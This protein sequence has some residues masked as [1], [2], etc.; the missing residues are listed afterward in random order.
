MT[1]SIPRL[2][3]LSWV[4]LSLFTV[5]SVAEPSFRTLEIEQS[6]LFEPTALARA[7]DSTSDV[8]QIVVLLHG[9]DMGT[10]E[11]G[12]KYEE[13]ARLVSERLA[14]RRALVLGIQWDSGGHSF[15][16]P[17]GDYFATLQ[18]ARTIGRG[19]IRQLL[20][21]LH[22]RYPAAPV[23]LLAH[24]M[25]SEIALA[26]VAPEI[27]YPEQAPEGETYRPDLEVRLALAVFAGSDLDYDIWKQS[28]EAAMNWFERVGLTWI[29]VADPVGQGDKV[30]SLRTRF[31]GKAAG[32]LMPLMTEAQLDR[33]LPAGKLLLDDEAIP[34]DHEL[35]SYFRPA[36]IE[37][38]VA[39][40]RFRTDLRARPPELAA[41]ATVMHTPNEL[42]ALRRHLDS[43]HAGAA[44]VALW[45]LEHL[46]CGDSRHL[47]DQTLEEAVRLL[48]D[49]PKAIWPLQAH[50]PCHT[51]R[52][53]LFPSE[54]TMR[55]AGAPARSRPARYRL[56]GR[57]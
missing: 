18:R 57:F 24:S 36:R 39:T 31:R 29:T 53:G 1:S 16:N 45:R 35:D 11:S 21:Q 3:L 22:N 6:Q 56:P 13:L 15:L 32:S 4:I 52:L 20:L 5:A 12:R 26:A 54:S 7:L 27:S 44:F 50:S 40:L 2:A 55:R 28:G 17:L 33:V 8:L 42:S 47:S 23:T 25:G 51:L 34:A 38:I 49:R 37:R 9:Y 43:P 14:P 48:A 41:I 10:Q 46:L 19:P 30:L